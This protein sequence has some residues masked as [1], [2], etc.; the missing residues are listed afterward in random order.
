MS[1]LLYGLP[2]WSQRSLALA[3]LLVAL[4]TPYIWLSQSINYYL[5][6]EQLI[7]EKREQLWRFE[8]FANYVIEQPADQLV[9]QNGNVTDEEFLGQASKQ[10]MMAHLQNRLKAIA[11]THG[12]KI[13]AIGS[14]P[15]FTENNVRY[16]GLR[17]STTGDYK[18]IYGLL[19]DVETSRPYL[20]VRQAHLRS[21]ASS[22]R[23][24]D[25][26]VEI[27]A[28]LNIY[29]AV[30]NSTIKSAGLADES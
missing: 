11:Q 18:S 7:I 26:D 22:V 6:N 23:D 5:G 15:E 29:G 13:I 27:S 21:S 25:R 4:A 16:I 10:V 12:T 9:S 1:K 17:M 2:I 19:L 28:Q 30:A 14:V 8:S 20:F 24:V 3:I